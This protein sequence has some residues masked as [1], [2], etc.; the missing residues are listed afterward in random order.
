MFK[1][2]RL[3]YKEIKSVDDA[4]EVTSDV[5]EA[6]TSYPVEVVQE[7]VG[8]I[9]EVRKGTHQMVEG[10]LRGVGKV[11][12]TTPKDMIWEG[13]LGGPRKTM[14]TYGEGKWVQATAFALPNLALGAVNT[15]T[16]GLGGVAN[17][18]LKVAGVEVVKG[19]KKLRL[20]ERSGIAR[21]LITWI[22]AIKKSARGLFGKRL[23]KKV[24]G[25]PSTG[26]SDSLV[27]PYLPAGAANTAPS[28][29]ASTGSTRAA[30]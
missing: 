27:M 22:G 29:P 24:L 7:Q 17:S 20:S 26:T 6:V 1:P 13:I 23:A 9:D 25:E 10:V 12:I 30:A 18:I 14:K 21:G 16:Y 5:L 15:V 8:A 2:S 3:I 19:E 4:A 11:A 28:A